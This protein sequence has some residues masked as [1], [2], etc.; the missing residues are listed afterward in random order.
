MSTWET[1]WLPDPKSGIM[2]GFGFGQSDFLWYIRTQPKVREAFEAIW[3]TKDL[4]VSFD[5]GNAFRPHAYN[6]DWL[7][8]GGWWH[9]D[10]NALNPG[11]RGR[12][13]VQG[14]VNLTPASRLSGGLCVIDGSHKQHVAMCQRNPLAKAS[15]GEFVPVPVTDPLLAEPGLLVCAEAGDLILWDS[16]TIH[17]NTPCLDGPHP[18]LPMPPPYN[19]S[20][21]SPHASSGTDASAEH[22]APP[23]EPSSSVA[24]PP[25]L[26]RVAGYVCMTP[27]SFASAD[28][29]KARETAYEELTSTS[30]WPHIFKAAG[31]AP[32]FL[33]KR[34]LKDASPAVRALVT[35]RFGERPACSIS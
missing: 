30:H 32:H 4:L 20:P 12:K 31:Y 13:C 24:T 29:L 25:A 28:T 5:G 23:G 33:D 9:T 35:G 17:C 2:N 7:T 6:A 22:E 10:M 21:S 16:R 34:K 11:Q 27:R 26:L 8:K 18:P 19:P 3:G 15:P 1:E 14:V